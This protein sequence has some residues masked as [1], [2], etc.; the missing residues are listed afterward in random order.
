M[1][2]EAKGDAAVLLMLDSL[3]QRHYDL[4]HCR[5][6]EDRELIVV[7]EHY[8]LRLRRLKEVS[9]NTEVLLISMDIGLGSAGTVYL[10]ME[11]RRVGP[12]TSRSRYLASKS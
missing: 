10:D 6:C 9:T 1:F 8:G 2:G 11:K 5:I 12:G 4:M 7:I 3:L